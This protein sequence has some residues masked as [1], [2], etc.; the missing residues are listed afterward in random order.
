MKCPYCGFENDND[1]NYCQG[2]GSHVA[3]QKTA[4]NRAASN[5][6]TAS[7]D[8]PN[9][10]VNGQDYTPIGMWGCTLPI[11]FCSPFRLLDLSSCASSRSAAR[12][13]STCAI[14]PARISAY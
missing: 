14:L 13:T 6:N 9:F 5:W 8:T 2:C 1:A 10:F 12:R 4:Q 7:H 3:G 11:R